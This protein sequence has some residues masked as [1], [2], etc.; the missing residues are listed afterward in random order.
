M[1]KKVYSWKQVPQGCKELFQVEF[2]SLERSG[3]TNS[4]RASLFTRL[5]D[6]HNILN[7]FR[8]S[9]IIA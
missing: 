3:I 2:D 4:K 9:D 7:H 1:V 5:I 6:M 8:I